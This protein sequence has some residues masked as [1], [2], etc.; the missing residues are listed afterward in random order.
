M[1]EKI[2]GLETSLN[3]IYVEYMVLQR[4]NN[5]EEIRKLM[6]QIQEF[7]VWFLEGNQFGIEDE[8]YQDMSRNLLDIL[9]DMISAM[10]YGDRVLLHDAA[11]YGFSE[12]LRLFLPEQGGEEH[13]VNI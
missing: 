2:R 11:A 13:E 12:Y 3:Q 4:R 1:E 7:V 5:I 10:E 6:P 9:K 8:L